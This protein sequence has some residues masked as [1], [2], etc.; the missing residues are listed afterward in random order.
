MSIER[1]FYCYSVSGLNPRASLIIKVISFA[2]MALVL[3]DELR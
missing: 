2:E 1:A 3:V